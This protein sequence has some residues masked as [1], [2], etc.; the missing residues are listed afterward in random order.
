M[1]L[2]LFCR[3]VMSDSFV[4]PWTVARQ[5][6][7]SSGISQ[8]RILEWVAVSSYRGSSHIRGLTRVSYTGRW[9]LYH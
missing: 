4:T 7:L 5:V 3:S 9:I 1:L 8:A 6:P 2:L